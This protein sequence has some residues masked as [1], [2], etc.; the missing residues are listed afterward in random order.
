VYALPLFF[1]DYVLGSFDLLATRPRALGE[2]ALEQA[3]H[4]ADA[5]TAALMPTREVLLTGN[6]APAWEPDQ[7]VR[8]HRFDTSRA[9]GALATRRRITLRMPSP[10]CAPRPSEGGRSLPG[11][12][13]DILRDRNTTQPLTWAKRSSSMCSPE[14]L[15][16]DLWEASEGSGRLCSAAWKLQQASRWTVTWTTPR[17]RPFAPRVLTPARLP[18]T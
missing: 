6:D 4:V 11:I 13:T 16:G 9:V 12:T 10:S 7:V 8:A 2:D 17:R 15:L 18:A 3:S 5:V 14:L 1:D